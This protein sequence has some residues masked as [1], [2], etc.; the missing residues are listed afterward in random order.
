MNTKSI[1]LLIAFYF[2]GLVILM[3]I[4][5]VKVYFCP[6]NEFVSK[7]YDKLFTFL[8]LNSILSIMIEGYFDLTIATILN[9][10]SDY[11]ALNVM[12]GDKLAF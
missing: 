6:R 7:L 1:S 4:K 11:E 12:S 3:I 5:I 2:A 8:I 9:I 10:L